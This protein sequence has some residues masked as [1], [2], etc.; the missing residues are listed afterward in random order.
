[1]Y[2]QPFALPLAIF[3]ASDAQGIDLAGAPGDF[4]VFDVPGKCQVIEAGLIITE[5]VVGATTFGRV[6][7]D[8]RPAAGSDTGRGDGDV[9]DFVL[10]NL[11]A[12]PVAGN[13]V[14]SRPA[15]AVILYPGE[16]VVVQLVA[17]S[18]PTGAGHYMPYL[19]AYYI[20]ETPANLVNVL[21][22]N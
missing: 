19:M 3:G 1:M 14:V 9:A 12:A 7:F 22:I 15:S 16:Q 6:A 17:A 21:P 4:A 18:A 11:A 10:D 13:V 8:K 5:A 2:T 20:A